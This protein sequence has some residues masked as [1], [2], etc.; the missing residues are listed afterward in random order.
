MES[1]L[2]TVESYSILDNP[3]RVWIAAAATLVVSLLLVAL[4][5]RLL[6]KRFA[7]AAE[8]PTQ[9][10]DVLSEIAQRTRLFLLFFLFLYI[11]ARMLE[12]PPKVLGALRAA[13]VIASFL[14]LGLWITGIVEIWLR[15][16]RTTRAETDPSTLTALGV[17]GFAAK[18]AVWAVILLVALQNLGINVTAL[19]TG[20]GIGGIAVALAVQNI[21]GDLFASISILVDKPFVV[22]DFII[23]GDQMG[24]VQH[25]G[26]KT[27][28]LRSLSGEQLVFSNSDLLQSRIRNFRPLEERRALFTFGVTYQTSPEL[29]ERI[30]SIVKEAIERRELTRFDR[31]HFKTFGASS[32]DFEVVYFVLSPQMP[33]YLDIQQAVNLEIMRRFAEEGIEFA[34]PTQTLHV[35][36][37][38]RRRS[39]SGSG[40]EA[41]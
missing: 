7:N 34:Y 1:Y 39:E 2:R 18:V 40:A 16:Y 19:V 8:T 17:A 24:T 27:T 30:P 28:R 13:A 5:R 23:V 36:S 21:L 33:I 38:E 37:L 26:L 41:T 20:L 25:V 15:R 14:Q 12:L 10:D 11:A 32:L 22:G 31:A 29:L 9:V 4:V 3:L 6:R 35:P